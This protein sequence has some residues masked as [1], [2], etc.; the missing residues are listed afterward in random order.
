[1]IYYKYDLTYVYVGEVESST[2]VDSATTTAPIDDTYILYD[3]DLDVWNQ[4]PNELSLADMQAV[5]NR[6]LID[7][8]NGFI[9]TIR[10]GIAD[11]E[12]GTFATQELEWRAWTA[13]A[14]APTPY[15]NILAATRGITK[16][17]LMYR[18]GLKITYYANIQ[19]KLHSFQDQI[20]STTTIAELTAIEYPWL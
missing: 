10:G 13:D 14:A 11:F 8:Y 16:E 12:E 7:Y 1:M 15:V 9:D 2:T 6:Q 19:G 4:L 3:P 17:D 20:N 5:Y 18:I